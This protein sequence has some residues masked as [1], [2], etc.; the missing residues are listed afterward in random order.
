MAWEYSWPRPNRLA[1]AG[2]N[3]AH[4]AAP[5]TLARRNP[6]QLLRTLRSSATARRRRAFATARLR[7]YSDSQS[8]SPGWM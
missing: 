2:G 7:P 6:K 5:P 8:R 4:P 1:K 3:T